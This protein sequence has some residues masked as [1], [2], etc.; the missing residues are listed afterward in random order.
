MLGL[1]AIPVEEPGSVYHLPMATSM[2]RRRFLLAGLL[3]V[4]LGAEAQGVGK[5]PRIGILVPGDPP[6]RPTP[7]AFRA[8]LRELGYVEDRTIVFEL[9]WAGARP[10]ALA[11][12]RHRSGTAS[13]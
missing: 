8:A 10:R 6:T 3:A 5:M 7:E 13:G 2:N 1:I 11:R 12:A 9:R 4:P